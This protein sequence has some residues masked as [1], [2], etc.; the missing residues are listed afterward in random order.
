ME[1]QKKQIREEVVTKLKSMNLEERTVKSMLVKKEVFSTQEYNQSKC[2][3]S[4]ISIPCEIETKELIKGALNDGKI[5]AVPYITDYKKKNMVATRIKSLSDLKKNRLGI[6]QPFCLD[7]I[8]K[9]DID[10]FLVPA[11]AFDCQGNR[12]G[13]GQGYFDR[14][15][16]DIQDTPIF[17][18]AYSFQILDSIPFNHFDLPVSKVITA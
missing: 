14:F 16:Q 4:Y 10:L 17:G 5:V 11:I 6:Y 2:I 1:N 15:L 18:L 9:K 12:L 13:R 8:D 3:F 7:I